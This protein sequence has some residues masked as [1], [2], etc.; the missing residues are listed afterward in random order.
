[1]IVG[2]A[3]GGHEARHISVPTRDARL[4]GGEAEGVEVACR[5]GE[6]GGRILSLGAE[7]RLPRQQVVAQVVTLFR[8]SGQPVVEVGALSF[9]SW[10]S[11]FREVGL[12][13]ASGRDSVTVV[14]SI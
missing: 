1:M 10:A 8:K 11:A 9:A 4:V 14:S 2:Q 5:E 6:E 12:V 7:F 13:K 3:V